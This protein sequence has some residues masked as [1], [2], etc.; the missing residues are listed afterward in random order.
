MFGQI[1]F[2]IVLLFWVG[3]DVYLFFFHNRR[4]S[5]R[6]QEKRSKY[7]MLAFVLSGMFGAVA[8]DGSSKEA[9]MLP[10]LPH[11]YVGIA[12]MVFAIIVRF[13]VVCQLGPS[14]AIDVGTLPGQELRTD[15][16]FRVIRHPAYAAEIAGSLGLAIVFDYPLS[17]I[18][19][20]TPPTTGI[21]YRISVEESNLKRVFGDAYTEY[22]KKTWRLIPYVF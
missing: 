14:F 15:R 17:S 21:L 7:I 10:F 20:F 11:R 19:A 3:F 4:I 8:V 16:M 1:F 13:L 12:L 6:L 18:L 5:R 2:F 22:C 9:F